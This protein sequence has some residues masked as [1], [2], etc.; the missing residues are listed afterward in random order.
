MTDLTALG[1]DPNVMLAALYKARASGTLEVEYEDGGTRRRIKYR[2]DRDL[3][4]AIAA[5]EAK[6]AGG[7]TV[8]VVNIRSEK[9]WT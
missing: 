4:N 3:A 7:P 1:L 6:V 2:S 5:I 9:G 8:N